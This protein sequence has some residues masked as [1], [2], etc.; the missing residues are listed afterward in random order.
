MTE[1]QHTIEELRRLDIEPPSG[2]SRLDLRNV[3]AEGRRRRRLHR[4]RLAGGAAMA[5]LAVA[6]AV[7]AALRQVGSE[8]DR[9]AAPGTAAPSSELSPT[10]GASMNI[11]D[12]PTECTAKRLPVP[13]GVTMSLITAGDPT[14]RF[15]AGR[16]Y[17][18][19]HQGSYPV[20][21]WENEKPRVVSMP[22]DDQRLTDINSRGVAVG[23]GYSGGK[24]L[25]YV[26]R[27]GRVNP[28]GGVSSGGPT[29][30]NESDRIVG[31]REE[32]GRQRPVV[33]PAPDQPA[34]D[35]PLPGRDWDGRATGVDDDGTV[36]GVVDKVDGDSDAAGS[37]EAVGYLW[38][39]DGGPARQLPMPTV[40]GGQATG[41]APLS[42]R[43]GWI[44][45]VASRREDTAIAFHAVRYNLAKGE[46]VPFTGRAAVS[47]GNGRGW[48]A[49]RSWGGPQG[50][51]D[52]AALLTDTGTVKLPDLAGLTGGEF[53]DVRALS[54]D[55]RIV[56]GQFDG[57]DGKPQAIV[58]HCR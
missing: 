53:V 58:W 14:G 40:P 34:R 17:P 11:P 21:I 23:S 16:S 32:N 20:V 24:E 3:I 43:N 15:L 6:V 28:L 22:G 27:D 55:G 54:D 10:A 41:L 45:A 30:I 31:T 57:P 36:V 50:R 38:P 39:A 42:I 5:L 35:L 48:G 1:D 25:P 7:P 12:E 19:G 13:G 51:S 46:Y 4:T 9:S 2:P 37:R 26:Y 49:G 56:G 33:W 44:V 8:P 18:K 29:A 52:G 47:V